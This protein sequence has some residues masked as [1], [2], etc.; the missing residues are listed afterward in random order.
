MSESKK[1]CFPDEGKTI[2]VDFDGVLH[3]DD[4]GFHDGTVYGRPIE[5]ARQGLEELS[6]KYKVVVFTAK[7]KPDRPLIG[8]KTGEELIWEWLRSNEMDSYVAVVSSEKPRA[9]AF[10]DDKAIR[11]NSWAITMEFLRKLRL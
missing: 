1:Y 4:K 9:V 8:G 3:D 11:F 6:S 5:G 10:I 7:A 2:G